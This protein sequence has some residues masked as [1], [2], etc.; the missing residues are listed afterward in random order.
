MEKLNPQEGSSIYDV[1]A[2]LPAPMRLAAQDRRE[3]LIS[4]ATRLFAEQGFD[5]TST[6]AIAEEAGVNEALIFR[7]FS[8]KEELY[9]EV[10]L[11]RVRV[12]HRLRDLRASL[13][14]NNEEAEP[15]E[16]LAEVA[17]RLL[18]RSREDTTLTRLLLFSALRNDGLASRF[19]QTY[20]ADA[21][22]LLCAYLRLG[23]ER[24]IFREADPAVV[25][26]GFLG[27]IVCHYLA[28]ELF[29]GNQR[30]QF[31]PYALAGQLADLWLNGISNA[32]GADTGAT[33]PAG[34]FPAPARK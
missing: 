30:Q 33:A 27:S 24:G 1:S 10:V 20:V 29:G 5:A 8:S 2:Y 32:R 23:M 31:E 14:Q 18:E 4:A 21:H 3:Q 22:E 6:R 34:V 11:N 17:G 9:E 25:A 13:E 12:T 15:R 26:R 28:Q 7:Y 16:V 19:F